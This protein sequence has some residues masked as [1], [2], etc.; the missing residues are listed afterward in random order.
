MPLGVALAQE[1]NLS[2]VLDR[3]QEEGDVECDRDLLPTLK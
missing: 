2:R 3:G 1:A